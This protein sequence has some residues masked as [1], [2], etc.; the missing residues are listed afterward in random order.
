M[1]EPWVFLE[2][3]DPPDTETAGGRAPDE[4]ALFFSAMIYGWSFNYDI[5]EKVRG[6]AEGFT[7]TPW[8]LSPRKRV[9]TGERENCSEPGALFGG[10]HLGA[11]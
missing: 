7:L 5:G 4:S 9:F 6:I 2:A 10:R 11:T 8:G 3:P 1:Q